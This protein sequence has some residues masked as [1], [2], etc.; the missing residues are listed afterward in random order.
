[1][2]TKYNNF[3]NENNS[4]INGVPIEEIKKFNSITDYT[5]LN[6][7]ATEDN[8]LEITEKARMIE[9][10]S[11]CI[12]PKMVRYSNGQLKDPNI[13]ICTV[14]SFPGGTN[15]LEEKYNETKKA[16][17]DGADEI[18]MVLNYQLL[19]EKWNSETLNVDENTHK[20]LLDDIKQL[21]KLCHDNNAIL[22]VIVESGKLDISQ[23]KYATQL[24]IDANA[25][26]IKTST[27]KVDIGAELDKVKAM[28]E[29]ITENGS[30]LFIKASGG[31][32]TIDDL[33]KFS[34]YVDRFGIGY[35]SVDKINGLTKEDK[36]DY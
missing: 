3:I 1:M 33:R 27:G 11:I 32:R 4:L 35:G 9:P 17:D 16:L 5:E 14:I 13:L 10:K 6:P 18:D 24:C 12:L 28:R 31:I 8:I 15:M 34:P 26:F 25:D 22:K 2:I 20:Y 29:I 7:T 21:S 19:L 36:N 30:N 23:T